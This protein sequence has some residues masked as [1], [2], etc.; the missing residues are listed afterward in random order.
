M[1][2]VTGHLCTHA[3]PGKVENVTTT[4]VL[5]AAGSTIKFSFQVSKKQNMCLLLWE[6]FYV[7]FQIKM[8]VL[9]IVYA[10]AD[11]NSLFGSVAVA[12]TLGARR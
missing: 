8:I 1:R 7:L 9:W 11:R 4:V 5:S 12:E 6:Q 3:V 2:N 10:N